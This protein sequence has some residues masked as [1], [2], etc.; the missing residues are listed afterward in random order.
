[1]I[2]DQH[3]TDGNAKKKYGVNFIAIEKVLCEGTSIYQLCKVEKNPF[4]SHCHLF[5]FQSTI[6]SG[7]IAVEDYQFLAILIMML[8]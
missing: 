8:L 5:S 6:L 4:D 3:E 1:M 7:T 2:G